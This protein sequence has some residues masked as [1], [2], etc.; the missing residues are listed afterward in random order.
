MI[1]RD[2]WTDLKNTI[3]F[4]RSTANTNLV[5]S[6]ADMKTFLKLDSS[7]TADDE[8]IDALIKSAT[9]VVENYTGRVLMNETWKMWATRLPDRVFLP[10]GYVSSI[11]SVTIIADDETTTTQTSTDYSLVSSEPSYFFLKDG[12]T[13]DT[14]NRDYGGYMVTFVAGYGADGDSVPDEI[15]NAVKVT[16]SEWYYNRSTSEIPV[17]AKTM[18]GPYRIPNVEIT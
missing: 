14:T 12:Y 16:V 10:F 11:T 1:D 15:L 7:I 4:Q 3:T 13:W 17:L 6:R 5:V 2:S 8:I 18:L 9:K